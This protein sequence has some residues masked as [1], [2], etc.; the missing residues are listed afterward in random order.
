MKRKTKKRIK[1]QS[2][3]IKLIRIQR[4]AAIALAVAV[5]IVGISFV[6]SNKPHHSPNALMTMDKEVATGCDLSYY[7]KG[8]DFESLKS[9]VDFLILRVG[10]TG[11]ASGDILLDEEFRD[12]AEAANDAGIP[13]GVYY[14]SQAVTE[15]EARA[16]AKFVLKHIRKYDISLPV[17]IDFEY[18]MDG[19]IQVGR[20]AEAELTPSESTQIINAF[21]DTVTNAG[22]D[23]GVYAS[24]WVLNNDLKA[25]K[26][27]SNAYIWVADYNGTIGYNGNYDLWQYT[28]K[29]RLESVSNGEGD[30]DLNY[31]YIKK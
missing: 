12:Y 2:C 18:P 8:V 14:Y 9:E 5:V 3:R 25:S 26:I 29:G 11:Y 28:N 1:K 20:L 10:Y 22:Y 7:N 17:F 31:W 27:N 13:L 21:C 16:E 30:V 23:C 15:N 19:G 6:V 24:S 4:I